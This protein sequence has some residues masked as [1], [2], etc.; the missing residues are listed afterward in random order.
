MVLEFLHE[1]NLCLLLYRL[2]SRAIFTH[3]ECVVSPDELDWKFHKGCH[4]NSRF[5]VVR[6]NKESTAC[7]DDTSVESHTD[8]AAS[9]S[10]LCHTCLEECSREVTLC[11]CMSLVQETVCLV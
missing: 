11:E 10:E 1:A 2:M 3:T 7:R 9:H 5:H 4:T 8:A 6:E